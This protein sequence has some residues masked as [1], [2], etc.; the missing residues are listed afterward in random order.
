MPQD[1][2]IPDPLRELLDRFQSGDDSA[3][4]E[5]Y[6][7]FNDHVMRVV[8]RRMSQVIRPRLDTEDLAQS[9]WTTLWKNRQR[10]RGLQD[11]DAAMAFIVTI[12]KRKAAF[13]MRKHVAS[14]KRSV[15]SEA[16]GDDMIAGTPERQVASPS[17]TLQ[18]KETMEKLVEGE[19]ERC[20]DIVNCRLSGMTL[21]Q[22][23][24]TV[25]VDERTV[26]RIL[27]RLE[28]KLSR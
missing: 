17:Q 19:S 10:F 11:S 4:L 3:A 6:D 2:S 1:E 25:G 23:A 22:V 16:S 7:F 18:A 13:A 5:L 12:A 14:K 24:Q 20:R 9:V 8:R 26:R 15:R 27:E 21:E 28:R